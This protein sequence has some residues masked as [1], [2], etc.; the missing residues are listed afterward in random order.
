MKIINN[1]NV[2]NLLIVTVMG[3]VAFFSYYTYIYYVEYESTRDS[4]Q[5]TYFIEEMDN[6]LD[7]VAKERLYSAMY[8]GTKGKK[9]FDKVKEARAVV[10]TAIAELD[11]YV[12]ANKVF[13]T[14]TARLNAV[15]NNLKNVRLR[16]DT[17]SGNYKDVFYGVYHNQI[18]ISLVGAMKI[19]SS[20]DASSAMKSYLSTYTSF[21]ELKENSELENAG[22]SFA[23]SG[24][25][26]MSDEDLVFWDSILVNDILPEFDTIESKVVVSKLNEAL[27]QEEFSKIGSNERIQILYGSQTGEYTVST[28]EWFA[29][30]E[31]KINYIALAQNILKSSMDKHTKDS[32]SQSKEV[33]TE[34]GM[35][36]IIALFLLLVLFVIYYNINKDKQLF[37]D[38]LKDIEAVLN[39]EQQKEL[40]KLIENREINKI[41]KFLT[42]TIREANQAKDL[43]LANMSHEIR[44]PLNGI[45]G[46]TQL[47][48]STPV[49]DEQEEFITVIENSSDNL[50]TIVNDILDLSKIKADKIELENIS[51]DAVE[52]FESAIE[53]YGARAA[54]KDIELG[55]YVDPDIPSVLIGDPTKISQI[56]VNLISNAVKFTSS[57]GE[58]D[59][60][61]EKLSENDKESTV[62]FS[63]K[64]TGIGITEEQKSKIFDA[65][66]QADVST[67]RKFGGTGL[68]LAISAKL[69]T[70][71]GGSLDIESKEGEGSTFFFTLTFAKPEE[72]TE[73][74]V[75]NMHGLEIALV[76]P[77]HDMRTLINENL[78]TYIHTAGAELKT[79]TGEELL[80]NRTFDLPDILFIDHR[81]CSREGE[82]ESYLDLDTKIVLLTTGDKK[83]QIEVLQG[84]IDRIV[85]KPV[86]LTKTF[87][88]LDVIYDDNKDKSESPAESI[89]KKIFHDVNALVAED[90][91]IN[92]K[93]I[94]NILTG[95]GLDVTIANNGEEALD[96]RKNE[97]YD[98]IFMDIQMPVM[99]GIEATKKIL[100]YEEKERKH[101]VPIVAL[102]ANALQGDREKYIDAGMDNYLSKPIEIVDLQNV[103]KEYLAHKMVEMEKELIEEEPKK[104]IEQTIEVPEELEEKVIEKIEEDK[105]DVESNA[106][107]IKFDIL[108]YK[109]TALATNIYVSMLNNL[110][111]DVDIATGV[112][113][114]MN[115]L[116]N[117]YY[118]Y[119]LFDAGSLMQI[120][121]LLSDLIR[122]RDAIP[123]MFISDKEK[124]SAC[125]STLS[126]DAMSEEI[127]NKLSTAL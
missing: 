89:N 40:T 16:V 114:F 109:E 117:K 111:Y 125:C 8:M 55:V 56:I 121:C 36:A 119:V 25:R 120:Q 105:V 77:N 41:Y 79:Y 17:L 11:H 118:H 44:T 104:E 12:K 5:S 70:F 72:S 38:T 37:E 110:G 71:M 7:T 65:F 68:G 53:S 107:N 48:K 96:L 126:I 59:V 115:K 47:L 42:N 10:D 43:F 52:K 91:S 20:Q 98:I 19:V 63:V 58:V 32:V 31:E 64:D 34:Y 93:L 57:R 35:G 73:K 81:Y 127:K 75:P 60:R 18:F 24:S 61:I 116:E 88:S 66:S 90:N 22:V 92:Q 82:L 124:D 27:T 106:K 112:D 9:G 80:E 101:H 49:T 3:A 28:T 67:S 84:S 86:N 76:V 113:S 108:L 87:K 123:F 97:E 23:L 51:F 94:N 4:T 45:V 62:K 78:E 83:K 1:K 122:D 29:K 26:K 33:M 74:I 46:F 103:I 14:Y 99:G 6:V 54:E 95:L 50:L 2:F 69:V 21:T 85:Y 100:K 13:Q 39:L 15:S 30:V 102:T